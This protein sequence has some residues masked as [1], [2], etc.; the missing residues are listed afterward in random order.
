MTIADRL[1]TTEELTRGWGEASAGPSIIEFAVRKFGHQHYRVA[2]A[3]FNTR[4]LLAGERGG[5][6]PEESL[7]GWLAGPESRSA[8]PDRRVSRHDVPDDGC[9]LCAR[10]RC[11][12]TPRSRRP[13]RW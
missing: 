10:G 5:A 8:Q 4:S 1:L 6:V 9:R 3:A 2:I 13:G 7:Y 12:P 11:R